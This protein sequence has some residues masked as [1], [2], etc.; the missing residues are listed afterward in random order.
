MRTP[1]L[2]LVPWEKNILPFHCFFHMFSTSGV[3]YVSWRKHISAEDLNSQ[4]KKDFL[5]SRE[6]TPRTFNDKRLKQ[7]FLTPH[8]RRDK[9]IVNL[10]WEKLMFTVFIFRPNLILVSQNDVTYVI[11]RNSIFYINWTW[12]RL[13]DVMGLYQLAGTGKSFSLNSIASSMTN[14]KLTNVYYY[15]CLSLNFVT[16][17]LP[18]Y[19]NP[20]NY[21]LY[22]I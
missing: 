6:Q 20:S 19:L 17:M 21:S 4:L 10:K 2:W 11:L 7:T 15:C 9:I 13:T 22:G 3:L 8:V 5:L 16:I 18:M 12:Q 14:H 1:V